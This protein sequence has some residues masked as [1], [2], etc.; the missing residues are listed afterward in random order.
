MSK[1]NSFFRSGFGLLVIIALLV[2]MLNMNELRSNAFNFADSP[3]NSLPEEMLGSSYLPEDDSEWITSLPEDQRRTYT[4]KPYYLPRGLSNWER[5][6]HFQLGNLEEHK[7]ESIRLFIPSG[8]IPGRIGDDDVYADVTIKDPKVCRKFSIALQPRYI[9]RKLASDFGRSQGGYG[10]GASLGVMEVRYKGVKKPLI[11][12][13]GKIGFYLDVWHGNDRQEFYSK[14]LSVA[15]D[16]TLRKY[17][18]YKIP[19]KYLA[20]QSGIDFLT[21]PD[22]LKN[23]EKK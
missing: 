19:A 10:A 15:I 7:I 2:L 14:A 12:G 1:N 18:K 20:K 13:I 23:F 22:E 4:E 9:L 3:P 16:Q 8:R 11:I 17:S 6:G 21:L 5:L